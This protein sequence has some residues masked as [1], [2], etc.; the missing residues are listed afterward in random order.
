MY[1]EE[2]EQLT[3]KQDKIT[4][5]IPDQ[6]QASTPSQ[7]VSPP[8]LRTVPEVSIHNTSRQTGEE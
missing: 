2:K 7:P 1:L 3:I 4:K 6:R 5:V 8:N